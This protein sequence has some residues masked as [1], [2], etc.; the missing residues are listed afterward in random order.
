MPM[1]ETEFAH[2]FALTYSVCL[3]I[4]DAFKT[5]EKAYDESTDALKDAEATK[6]V[7]EQ[8]EKTR[9]DATDL[10]GTVQ[11]T[12]TNDLKDLDDQL[13]SRPDLTPAAKQVRPGPTLALS[14]CPSMR[15]TCTKIN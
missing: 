1:R 7:L 9:D 15:V 14:S 8:S 4:P 13:A 12:N 6:P 5:I 11:L 3:H 2:C 10:E